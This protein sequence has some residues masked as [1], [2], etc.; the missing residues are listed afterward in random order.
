MPEKDVVLENRDKR[1]PF[2]ATMY[3]SI[4]CKNGKCLCGAVEVL[5]GGAPALQPQRQEGSFYIPPKTCSSPLPKEV[6]EIPQVKVAIREG[7][8][9]VK[10]SEL[11]AIQT[12]PAKPVK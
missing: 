4:V 8:L 1:R 10:G 6:L 12:I 3:H 7:W 5:S 11:I 9:R 2:E